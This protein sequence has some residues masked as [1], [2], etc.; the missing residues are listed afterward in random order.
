MQRTGAMGGLLAALF[1][2][3]V[4]LARAADHADGPRATVDPAADITDVF[5]WMSADASHVNLVM[6]VFPS[7]TTS[8]KFSDAIQYVFHLGSRVAFSNAATTEAHTDIICTFDS[9]QKASCW[10]GT[11]AYVTGDASTTNGVTSTD[12]KLKVFAGLRN[13]PFFFNLDGFKAT[14]AAVAAAA[15]GLSV[16]AAGCPALDTST[17]T[18]LVNQ[19]K[20][21]PGGGTAVDHFV[22]KN[23]LSIVLSLDK[24][25]VTQGGPVVSVWAATLK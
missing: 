22:G 3:G 2:T 4:P 7:A 13:D 6:N 12:G 21:A 23:V 11:A 8:S 15:S 24:T 9:A 17:A 5:A 14:A 19:L 16:D 10:V 1:L 18:A 25:L 20:T